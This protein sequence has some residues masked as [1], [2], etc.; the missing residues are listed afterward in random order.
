MNRRSTRAAVT[1]SLLLVSLALPAG[2]ASAQGAKSLVGTWTIVSD[3]TIDASGNRTPIFGPNPRGSLIFTAN[4]RYSVVFA[5][6]GLPKVAAN[7]RKKGTAEENKAVIAGSLAHFGKYSVDEKNNTF[8]FHVEVSTYPN[9][10]GTTQ[11]RPFIASGDELTYST[12]VASV[13]GRAEA[14]WRRIK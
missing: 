2:N 12:A 14:V 10:D 8:T 3:D 4:G 11:K 6:A 9:W 5:R 13:G 1:A 7:N